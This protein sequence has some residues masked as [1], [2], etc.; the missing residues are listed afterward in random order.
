MLRPYFRS[1]HEM[2]CSS[3][4]SHDSIHNMMIR[5]GF[6][7][8]FATFF[9]RFEAN[10]SEYGSYSLHIRMFR[11]FRQH[12]LFASYSFQNI[13]KNSHANI[14]FLVLANICFKIF[15]L[16]GIFASKYS[17]TSEYLLANICILLNKGFTSLRPQ[18]I[19]VFLIFASFCLKIFALKRNK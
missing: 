11:Y 16:K 17:H 5:L 6:C 18:L 15:V 3:T 7:A 2:Q 13:R 9:N 1:S 4:W 10:L 14:H 8:P 12:H 19:F